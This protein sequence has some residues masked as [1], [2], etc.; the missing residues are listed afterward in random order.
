VESKL[1]EAIEHLTVRSPCIAA[2]GYCGFVGC[3]SF[4]RRSVR[5][6]CS[7]CAQ[8]GLDLAQDGAPNPHSLTIRIQGFA[9]LGALSCALELLSSPLV[10]CSRFA[11]E[12]S[13]QGTRW[14]A[15]PR[16]QRTC[17][18]A[19]ACCRRR[20]GST[21]TARAWR[22]TISFL[23]WVSRPPSMLRRYE[24]SCGTRAI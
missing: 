15:S 18:S 24:G 1:N 22:W 19:S 14:N 12:L 6:C 2:L 20:S 9:N 7:L 21:P 3:H 17:T 16:S 5:Q 4:D 10:C 23:Q 13:T 8:A 11:L